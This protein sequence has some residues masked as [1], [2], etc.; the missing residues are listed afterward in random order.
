M[1]VTIDE[2]T[3]NKAISEGKLELANWLLLNS[4]PYDSSVYVQNLSLQVLNWLKSKDIDIPKNCLADVI[5]KSSDLTVINWFVSN[6]VFVNHS[7]LNSCIRNKKNELLF[8]LMGQSNLTLNYESFKTAILAE[9]IEVL[10]Y[11][12]T[13]TL[14]VDENITELAMKNKKKLSLKWL[15]LNNLF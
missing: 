8:H 10:D 6:G 1:K 3:F 12:K 11:L 2:S 15:V 4:C 7:S 9:N 5:D 13:G 14:T